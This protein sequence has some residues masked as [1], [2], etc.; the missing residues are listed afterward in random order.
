MLAA[1]RRWLASYL[2]ILVALASACSVRL[3]DDYSKGAE[4]GL[5]A[6]FAQ[7]TALYE[8]LAQRDANAR[9]FALSAPKWSE[10]H[11]A[12]QVQVLRE[13]ARPLN[14]ESYGMIAQIDTLLSEYR[15]RHRERDNYP[16]VLMQR[17]REQLFRAFSAAL[18]AE[19][20]REWPDDPS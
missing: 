4:D 17:H 18:R 5:V 20:I 15:R 9:A 19:R 13:S 1:R 8:E 6:T 14:R 3:L 10:I 2:L 7:V 11:Q 12:V 16:D